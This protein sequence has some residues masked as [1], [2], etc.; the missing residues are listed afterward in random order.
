[1][2]KFCKSIVKLKIPII[3]ISLFLLIP[4]VFGIAYT[5]INYDML[6]YLPKDIETMKGQDILLKDFGKGAFSFVIFEGM[7]DKDVVKAKEKIEKVDHVETALWY[8]S[9]VD[10]SIPKEVLPDKIYYK[11][12]MYERYIMIALML[13]LF[14]GVLDT[15][16]SFLTSVLMKFISI[17]PALIF[18]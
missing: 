5:R 7:D 3:I 18:G 9:L 6:D 15:P 17:I 12:M 16:I 14:I 2:I 13:L 10:I 1:M 4:S 8:D 11:Y